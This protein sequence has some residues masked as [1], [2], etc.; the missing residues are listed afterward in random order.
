MSCRST[1]QEFQDVKN[2]HIEFEQNY[3][4]VLEENEKLNQKIGNLSKEA[5]EL[6]LNL[7]ALKTEVSAG[8]PL[9]K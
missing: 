6:G 1:D 4:M 5:E 2:H 3:K 9:G 7:E 8:H